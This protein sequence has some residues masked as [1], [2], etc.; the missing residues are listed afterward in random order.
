MD[1]RKALASTSILG[2]S[3]SG[4]D[5]GVVAQTAPA[6]RMR[7]MYQKATPTLTRR[8]PMACSFSVKWILMPKP[9]P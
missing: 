9:A 5:S 1:R 8:R 7:V 3:L 2:F 6:P 4:L